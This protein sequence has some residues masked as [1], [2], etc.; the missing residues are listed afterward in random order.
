MITDQAK[1]KN[2]DEYIAAY[3][4]DVQEILEKIRETV[5]KAAPDAEETIKYGMP[6]FA[7]KG[8]LV[9]FGAFKSHIG[10]Y[11][12]PTGIEQ[13]KKELSAYQGAKGSVQFPL[14]KPMPYDLIS[15]I[16][17]FRVKEN[18][19]KAEAKAKKKK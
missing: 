13:F 18:L 11:P 4:K 16:V 19:E 17:A 9:H 6:T 5:R 14:D 7:L 3:P 8:N 10:F 15:R 2:I 1:P 12:V